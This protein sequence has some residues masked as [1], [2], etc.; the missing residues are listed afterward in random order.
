MQTS[1]GGGDGADA[2]GTAGGDPDSVYGAAI[3]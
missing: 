2:D 1:S 3:A